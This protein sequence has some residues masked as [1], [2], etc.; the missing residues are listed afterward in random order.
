[1]PVI[2][3]SIGTGDQNRPP[4]SDGAGVAVLAGDGV[5]VL[6]KSLGFRRKPENLS[7]EVSASRDEGGE[8]EQ[9][10]EENEPSHGDFRRLVGEDEWFYQWEEQRC[11][12]FY[13][14]FNTIFQIESIINHHSA[15]LLSLV[16]PER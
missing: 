3:V 8:S 1:M 5:A 16:G 4:G 11:G 12:K 2:P 14:V 10:Q 6:E 7:G 9:G 15:I 13:G